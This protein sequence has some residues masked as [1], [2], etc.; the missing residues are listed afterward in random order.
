MKVHWNKACNKADSAMNYMS[1]K[2]L[3]RCAFDT[4]DF[5]PKGSYRLLREHY[6]D[7]KAHTLVESLK[8]GL[9]LWAVYDPSEP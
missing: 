4:C 3:T 7:L 5:K 2:T 8:K 1:N 6:K 9:R